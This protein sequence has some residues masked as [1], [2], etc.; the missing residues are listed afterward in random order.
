[1]GVGLKIQDEILTSEVRGA[2]GEVEEEVGLAPDERENERYDSCGQE[3]CIEE[4]P[5]NHET[6]GHHLNGAN[7]F[8]MGCMSVNER[9]TL[10]RLELEIKTKGRSTP[11][12]P[13]CSR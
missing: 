6:L 9:T 2:K 4:K 13:A 3:A 5:G 10:D 8:G 12:G 11:N 1:M 7:G